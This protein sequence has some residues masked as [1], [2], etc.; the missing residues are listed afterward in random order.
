MPVILTKLDDLPIV[1]HVVLHGSC[2]VHRAHLHQVFYGISHPSKLILNKYDGLKVKTNLLLFLKLGLVRYFHVFHC[3]FQAV[4]VL[5]ISKLVS[6]FHSKKRIYRVILSWSRVL[7]WLNDETR[8]DKVIIELREGRRL[9]NLLVIRTL[10]IVRQ[11]G[12]G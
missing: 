11:D 12:A 3:C 4:R 7:L 6:D 10:V 8:I 2:L 1:V 5:T 9:L